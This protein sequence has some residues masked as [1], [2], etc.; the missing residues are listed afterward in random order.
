MT[1]TTEAPNTAT[2]TGNFPGQTL[3][4]VGL[5][6]AF[7]MSLAGIV[8]SAIAL[9]E[10]SAAGFK[11]PIAQAGLITS[12]VLTVVGVMAAIVSIVM[13]VAIW[14]SCGY[15]GSGVHMMQNGLSLDC[16]F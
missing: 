16:N 13:V 14:Q 10:S 3:G 11:N 4:I 12:V 6:L 5:V 9:R 1:Q 7:I 15:M 8:V 2:T